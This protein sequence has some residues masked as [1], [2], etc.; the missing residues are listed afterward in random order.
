MSFSKNAE[1]I[2][3][4]YRG[5]DRRDSDKDEDEAVISRRVSFDSKG[6]PILDIRT[7]ALR[8]REDDMTINL[9]KCLDI[10]ELDFDDSDD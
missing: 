7:N 4:S 1:I 8:R 9:L 10:S 2:T 6:N 3:G 5:P